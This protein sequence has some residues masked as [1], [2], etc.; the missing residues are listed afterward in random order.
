MTDEAPTGEPRDAA[1]LLA[2]LTDLLQLEAD[3][4]PAYAVAI[5]GLRRPDYPRRNA[6]HST[7]SGT[8]SV[9]GAGRI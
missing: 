5:A 6:R 1:A 4:L 3:A 9:T 7:T 2:D 8:S